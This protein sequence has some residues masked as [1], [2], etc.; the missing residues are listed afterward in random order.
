MGEGEVSG[1]PV[2][3]RQQLDWVSADLDQEIEGCGDLLRR[4]AGMDREDVADLWTASAVVP[5]REP[6]DRL[7]GQRAVGLALDR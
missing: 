2:V 5:H 1:D 6:A 7:A 3:S 4:P